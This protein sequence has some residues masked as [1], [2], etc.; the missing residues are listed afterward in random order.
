MFEGHGRQPTLKTLYMPCTHTHC[1][2]SRESELDV[3][4]SGHAKIL[5][6]YPFKST[7]YVECCK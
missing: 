3:M 6:E 7:V 5:P 4:F 2:I 1:D